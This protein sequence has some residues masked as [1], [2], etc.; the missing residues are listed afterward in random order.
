VTSRL[1]P[2]E[3]LPLLSA[4]ETAKLVERIRPCPRLA[5]LEEA[6]ARALE[7]EVVDFDLVADR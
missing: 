7:P 2:R 3:T 5:E 4:E 1:N 6:L